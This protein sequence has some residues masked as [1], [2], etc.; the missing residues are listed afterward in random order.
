[1]TTKKSAKK[2]GRTTKKKAKP[3]VDKSKPWVLTRDE[4]LDLNRKGQKL[5]ERR[6]GIRFVDAVGVLDNFMSD[7][8]YK[9]F[10]GEEVDPYDVIVNLLAAAYETA[11]ATFDFTDDEAFGYGYL[12]LGDLMGGDSDPKE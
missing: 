12:S 10:A 5:V 7:E 11:G 2:P 8:A 6:L 3:E 4:F 1:M 9:N